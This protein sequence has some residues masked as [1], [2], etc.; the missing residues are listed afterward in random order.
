M[1]SFFL[2]LKCFNHSGKVNPVF[3]ASQGKIRVF[4]FT[5]K[6]EVKIQ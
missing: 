1:R 5:C 6:G 3:L 4:T 2:L